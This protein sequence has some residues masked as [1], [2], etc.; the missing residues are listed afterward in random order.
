MYMVTGWGNGKSGACHVNAW[1]SLMAVDVTH[2][3]LALPISVTRHVLCC[4]VRF[5]A[6]PRAL[7]RRPT[8]L[9]HL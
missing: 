1:A 9:D 6:V 2:M 7:S 4:A 8:G 3:C 5:G